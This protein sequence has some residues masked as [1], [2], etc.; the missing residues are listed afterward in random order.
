MY[1]KETSYK[2]VAFT[3]TMSNNYRVSKNK[4]QKPG[5]TK[6]ESTQSRRDMLM[7]ALKL[8]GQIAIANT[9]IYSISLISGK[10]KFGNMTAAA[11]L[12]E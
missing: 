4:D 3:G 5:E 10:D 8:T 7:K 6:P 12:K 11:V 9:A 2:I 1:L